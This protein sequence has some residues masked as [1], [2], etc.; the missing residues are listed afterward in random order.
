MRGLAAELA[1]CVAA[2]GRV[3][4]DPLADAGPVITGCPGLRVAV[5]RQYTCAVRPDGTLACWGDNA[6]GQL[7]NGTTAPSVTP[8]EVS[9]PGPVRRVAASVNTTCALLEDGRLFCWGYNSL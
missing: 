5:G 4:F 1:I 2:C 3:A 7:G 6:T 8:V 9:L